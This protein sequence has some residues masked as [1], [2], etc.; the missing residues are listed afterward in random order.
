LPGLDLCTKDE[1]RALRRAGNCYK[2]DS[3]AKS[4]IHKRFMSCHFS[5]HSSQA[6]DFS[7]LRAWRGASINKV[8]HMFDE[9]AVKHF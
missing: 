1:A 6:L 5:V 4:L 8:I 7:R 9:S 3:G 2:T